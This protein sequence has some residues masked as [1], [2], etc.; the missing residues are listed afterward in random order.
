[1]SKRG[2]TLVELV[3][4]VGI[5]AVLASLVIVNLSPPRSKSRDQKRKA[6]LLA[7]QGALELYFATNRS[8]PSTGGTWS[9]EPPVFGGKGYSGPD[10]YVPNL[11]P[12][13]ITVLPSDPTRRASSAAG[14]CTDNH[15]GY[16]YQSDGKDYKVIAN[17]T[18]EIAIS[19]R[20]PFYDPT[21]SYQ[22]FAV[23][24]AGGK[25]FR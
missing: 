16:L 15:A 25:N 3:I 5:I 1:M 20:D 12:N 22:V 8:F 24:S 10:G 11:A 2:F 6:D 18:P 13:F 21:F 23:Y 14:G 19:D 9:G 17:C 7:I 4:V